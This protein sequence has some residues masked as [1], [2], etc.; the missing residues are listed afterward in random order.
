VSIVPLT[1]PRSATEGILDDGRRD[2]E[3]SQRRLVMRAAPDGRT[4]T[5]LPRLCADIDLVE[6]LST[7]RSG[8]DGLALLA[9]LDLLPAL[10]AMTS[11]ACR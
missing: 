10:P 5:F 2:E 4:A 6:P 9:D 8:S 7:A 3:G 11:S 1:A